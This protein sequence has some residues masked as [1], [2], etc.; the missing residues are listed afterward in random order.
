MSALI[1]FHLS[2]AYAADHGITTSD[3]D[4]EQSYSGFEQ[5]VGKDTLA[6]QLQA[7]GVTTDDV[8]SLIRS[9]LTQTAVAKAV[10]EERLGPDGLRTQYENSIADY[11]NLHV[12]HILVKTEAE[13]DRIYQQVTAPGFTL[14]DFQALAKKVSIDPNAKQDGGELSLPATQLV[15][16]FADAATALAPGEISKPVQT[17]YGWHVIWK[18]GE[19]VQSFAKV[20]EPAAPTGPAGP[21]RRVD[22]RADRGRRGHRR[23]ELRTLR[24]AAARRRS[25]HEHRPVGHPADTD[26]RGERY[27]ATAV[28]ER[29]AFDGPVPSSRGGEGVL[30]LIRVQARLRAPDGCPWDREQT[31]RTLAR[32]LLEETH[33]LLEAID[34]D[35][36]AAIRDELGDLLLQV[37][38]HAQIANDEGRFDI[39]DVAD[40]LVAK[41][42]HRHPHVFGDV[43]VADA[44]EVLV[45][46][47]KLKAEETGGRKSVDADIPATLPALARA[48]KVQRRAAGWGFTWRDAASA[49]TKLQEEVDELAAAIDDDPDQVEA[50]LGDVLLSAVAVARLRGL[51]AESALRRATATFATRAERTFALAVERGLDPER[52]NEDELLALYREAKEDS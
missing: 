47:E 50:E 22:A 32:H 15:P 48:A 51:D 31:H 18:I 40:G 25:H 3:A 23:S 36:E 39:D 42:V 10:T 41:L 6:T 1:L 11:T 38:F 45:N 35:D 46:W 24:P 33:E 28:S 2:D 37:T 34:A 29:L 21:V 26:R 4:V 5:G 27:D 43:E 8:K 14:A 16:E 19:D 49:M 7:N 9:S 44:G 20:E 17:Q 13:A 12:D 52:L 30:D